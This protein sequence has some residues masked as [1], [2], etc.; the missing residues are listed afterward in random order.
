MYHLDFYHFYVHKQ[1]QCILFI[2]DDNSRFITGWTLVSSERADPVVECFERAVQ[3]YG[4]PEGAMSDRGSAFHSWRGLFRF[5]SLL[6][7]LEFT[8]SGKKE[9]L[10]WQG[11]IDQATTC[12]TATVVTK[13]EDA[14][15]VRKAYHDSVELIGSPPGGMVHDNKPIYDDKKLRQDIEKRTVMIPATLKRPENKAGIEG[16][17]GKYEQHVGT[18]RINDQDEDS[19]NQNIVREVIRAYTSGINHAGRFEFDGKSRIMVLKEACPD[20]AKD[21]AFI[22][23]LKRRHNQQKRQNILPTVHAATAILNETFLAFNLQR[24]DP[25]GDLRAW[26]ASNYTPEGIRPGLAIWGAERE[27]GRLFSKMAH[28]YLVKVIQNSQKEIDLRVQEDQLRKFAQIHRNSRINELEQEFDRLST[29]C[30]RGTVL[31]NDMAFRLSENAAFGCII[32]QR[33]FRLNKLKKVL[34][35]QPD[36]I[37][38]VCR[39]IRRLFEVD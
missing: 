22:E 3:R 37:R 21:R 31:E 29:D 36:R 18:I 13:T 35:K 16:E 2:E 20:P 10:N 11:I 38:S 30:Q 32:V 33:D 12:H 25:K 26:L 27:K 34:M 14:N 5:E 6:E 24:N 1:K 28:R 9:T 7:E 8:S 15:A 17:F 39:H 4:R 23:Q 19:L